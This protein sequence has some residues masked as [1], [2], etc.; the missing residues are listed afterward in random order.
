MTNRHTRP[1]R[2]PPLRRQIVR[3]QHALTKA[4]N[5]TDWFLVGDL[6][7][8]PE[9]AAYLDEASVAIHLA[10]EALIQSMGRLPQEGEQTEL[11]LTAP[12]SRSA[13][14]ATCT[15]RSVDHTEGLRCPACGCTDFTEA[16]DESGLCAHPHEGPCPSF[17]DDSDDEEEGR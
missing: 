6:S 16:D 2:Q 9:I 1:D 5:H 11:D 4:V 17:G 12:I 14:C 8:G 15:H 3:A 10:R 13:V 7:D